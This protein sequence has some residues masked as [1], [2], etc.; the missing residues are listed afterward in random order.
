MQ[1][2]VT[3]LGIIVA[4]LVIAAILGKRNEKRA[5]RFYRNK[6]IKN[7]GKEPTIDIRESRRQAIPKYFENHKEDTALDDITWNDLGLDAVYDRINYCNSGAGQEY[8]YYRLRTPMQTD[9]FESFEQQ[10]DNFTAKEDLRVDTQLIFARMSNFGKHSLYDYIGSLDDLKMSSRLPHMIADLLMLISIAGCFF[11]FEV[12]FIIIIACLLYNAVTYFIIKGDI[13]PYLYIFGYINRMLGGIDMF[14][15][16][17]DEVL[18]KETRELFEYEKETDAFRR[19]S[20]IILD[21]ARLS[22][23]GDPMN[24]LLDY[25]CMFTHID[26]FKFKSMYKF[27]KTH[28]QLL[29]SIVTTLG[30]IETEISVACYRASLD[31]KYCLPEF[32]TLKGEKDNDKDSSVDLSYNAADLYHPCMKNPVVNSITADKGVLITGSNASGKSTF[33]KTSAIAAVMAQTI[34]TVTGSSYKAPIYRIYSSMALRDDLAG[35]DSYYIVEIKSLKRILDAAAS[36]G[37]RIFCL[38]DEVLRGTN[39]I[40]RIAASTQILKSLDKK[41]IQ[42][43]A[44]THD[45]ELTDLLKDYYDNY[46]FEG[47]VTDNDVHFSYRIQKGPA[48]TRNAIKLLSM[49]GYDTTIVEDAQKMADDFTRTGIWA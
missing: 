2:Y 48:T 44:A 35:G 15:S 19:G 7:W 27:V 42:C 38:I 18:A 23:S 32:E 14:K 36:K 47:E 1:V 43:F 45:I 10:V 29:D 39:T 11:K 34:H 3:V 30:R 20:W 26:L 9:E 49:I 33:L 4:I 46:H 21:P 28:G 40:E 5:E 8:L 16:V 13:S 31:G 25:I 22:N 41:N 17:K 37:S 12:F 24:M 6:F